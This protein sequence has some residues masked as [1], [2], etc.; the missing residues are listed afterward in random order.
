[1]GDGAFA[2]VRRPFTPAEIVELTL[3]A[4]FYAGVARVLRALQVDLEPGYPHD[5]I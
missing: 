5:M 2:A 1:V 4:G 3:T